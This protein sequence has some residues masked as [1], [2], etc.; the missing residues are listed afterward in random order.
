MA[1]AAFQTNA[2]Q[3]NAYQVT[4]FTPRIVYGGGG[5]YRGSSSNDNGYSWEQTARI[6]EKRR[7]EFLKLKQQEADNQRRL[8]EQQ[9]E[10]EKLEQRRSSDLANQAMQVELL[11]MMQHMQALDLEAKRINDLL[12]V[13]M[14]EEDDIVALLY[15][16][17]FVM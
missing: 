3:R 4:S 12:M 11:N 6:L 9:A 7:Q 13:F 17:P 8:E 14:R 16:I 5:T 2:Y 1:Y 10:I 15:A